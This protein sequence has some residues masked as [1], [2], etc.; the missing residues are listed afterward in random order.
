MRHLRKRTSTSHKCTT[1]AQINVLTFKPVAS[2]R[3]A[4]TRI[5][6]YST[7]EHQITTAAQIIDHPLLLAVRRH[8]ARARPQVRHL[9]TAPFQI[10]ALPI[11]S[12]ASVRS[13]L[14]RFDLNR[15]EVDATPAGA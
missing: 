11:K 2:V 8:P 10:D 5:E 14:N 6:I 12:V 7:P 3:L 1:P 15:I 4:L 9:I 13:G